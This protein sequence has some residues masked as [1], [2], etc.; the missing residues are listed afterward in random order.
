MK[1]KSYEIETPY[2]KTLDVLE[3]YIERFLNCL[4]TNKNQFGASTIYNGISA[5][6]IPLLT[7]YPV[8]IN[9]VI[10]DEIVKDHSEKQKSRIIFQ[11]F[12]PKKRVFK[13]F[14][15]KKLQKNV[16]EDNFYEKL[17]SHEQCTLHLA[18][19]LMQEG[20]KFE[21][22]TDL[23][24][25][26]IEMVVNN[27]YFLLNKNLLNFLNR[28]KDFFISKYG[29]KVKDLKTKTDWLN[30]SLE[31]V[32]YNKKEFID[33]LFKQLENY[34]KSKDFYDTF[35]FLQSLNIK[36][37]YAENKIK[38]CH[39]NIEKIFTSNI[40]SLDQFSI[41]LIDLLI[42]KD[43]STISFIEDLRK[44]YID[45][46]SVFYI[47]TNISNFF[48]GKN[49]VINVFFNIFNE[50]VSKNSDICKGIID[51]CELKDESSKSRLK[52]MVE[53]NDRI[54]NMKIILTIFF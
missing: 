47:T 11:L 4:V 39:I 45:S 48:K 27:L 46:T 9:K 5:H 35:L 8:S 25:S 16:E 52:Y 18:E 26:F 22:H 50:L 29:D 19:I 36:T 21:E 34:G 17:M 2:D 14:R 6:L 20:I 3:I 7:L 49:S 31:N 43:S 41:N 30:F 23:K 32:I 54:E 15:T 40:N 12:Y 28:N 13:R 38:Q 1:Q 24:N 10:M 51:V 33:N 37:G 53:T 42:S 44:R